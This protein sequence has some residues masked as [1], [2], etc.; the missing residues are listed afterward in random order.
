MLISIGSSK[1]DLVEPREL[2]SERTL[3]DH[4]GNVLQTN[5]F[6]D[7]SPGPRP[8]CFRDGSSGVSGNSH[9]PRLYKGWISLSL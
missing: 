2:S 4:F 3:Q 9:F 7:D 8:R 5:R 6:L 1:R